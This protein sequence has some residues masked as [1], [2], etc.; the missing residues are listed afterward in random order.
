MFG[1]DNKSGINAMP[2]IAPADSQT[3]KWFTE[4]GAGLSATY[5]GQ[6]WFNEIQAELL[7]VLNAAGIAPQK[8]NLSQL[9]SAIS[10]LASTYAISIVHSTGQSL[11]SVMSQK[12]VTDLAAGKVSVSALGNLKD[13]GEFK[14]FTKTGFYLSSI[15]NTSTVPDMP[16]TPSGQKLYGY[17]VITVQ[18]SGGVI[19]QQYTSHL[20][21]IATR[22]SW[23]GGDVWNSW[24]VAVTESTKCKAGSFELMPFRAG[25]LPA[26]W[27][28]A[29]GDL[30]ELTSPQGVVLNGLSPSY[31]TDWNITV[32]G[33]KIN[34]PNI[35][36]PDGRTP[37]LRP[38][39]GTNRQVGNV[40]G[41]K[42]RNISGRIRSWGSDANNGGAF[43]TVSTGTEALGGGSFA[44]SI[45]VGFSSDQAV[46]TGP[47][48]KPL[49][50]GVTLAI[51][52][53][54]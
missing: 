28:S 22:Q 19:N 16:S 8:G 17:G 36:Q 26:G 24:Q 49:D 14:S 41:D 6:D 43:T 32:T 4:G 33:G 11:T 3:P 37:F 48:N 35:R 25:E 40:D 53:G 29:N 13:G 7:N 47:E 54:V 27:Y 46:P 52:L 44:A 10:K 23:N 9:S 50:I 38:I 30:F 15:D 45:I 39:N 2:P 51:Y 20:G 31:K 12:A 5:P 1:L 21:E 42:I 34:I 18:G